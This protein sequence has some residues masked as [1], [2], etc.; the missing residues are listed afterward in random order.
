MKS[1]NSTSLLTETF[2]L[3]MSV[4][5]ISR[6]VFSNLPTIYYLICLLPVS[7]STILTSTI[8]NPN[9]YSFLKVTLLSHQYPI[10]QI[11]IIP[12][13][14]KPAA[15]PLSCNL[16]SGGYARNSETISVKILE[17][18][19]KLTISSSASQVPIGTP[20]T[21]SCSIEYYIVPTPAPDF[22]VQ[23]YSKRDGLLG[24]YEQKGGGPMLLSVQH[25]D[26]VEVHQGNRQA[27]AFP[28]FEVEL[29]ESSESTQEYWCALKLPGGTFE[30]E[31][32][33][34]IPRVNLISTKMNATQRLGIC[35]IDAFQPKDGSTYSVQ[36]FSNFGP[37]SVNLL[38]TFTIQRKGRLL[39]EFSIFNVHLCISANKL[40]EFLSESVP[41]WTSIEH[42]GNEIFPRFGII[43]TSASFS[44]NWW[45]TLNLGTNGSP[46]YRQYTSG[47]VNL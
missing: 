35:Q 11:Q 42:S 43:G 25:H 10:Y 29:T 22:Q 30:S 39:V 18:P 38:A 27:P 46:E 23:F 15:Y 9:N 20:F 5:P 40:E 2:S 4:S 47:K 1:L 37:G 8:A 44:G 13:S 32:W 12:K 28:L 7:N 6:C 17:S 24:S 14:A 19:P 36:F 41:G 34:N 16:V 3:K 45:C 31:H 26:H 33:P 21:L